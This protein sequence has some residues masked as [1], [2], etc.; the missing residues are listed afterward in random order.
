MGRT[1]TPAEIETMAEG[2]RRLARIL[3]ELRAAVRPGVRTIELDR[4]AH[5]LIAKG[6]DTP[7]FLGYKPGG[8]G[9]PYPASLCASVNDGV[10]HGV[11]SN[12][13]L[14]EGDVLKLDLGLVHKELY[15]DAA[16][17]V[18][19]G[20]ISEEAKKLISATKKALALGVA[21]AKAGNTLGDI[22]HAVQNYVEQLGF[23]VVRAL[24]GHGVGQSL[25]EDPYV[26]NFGKPG[27]GEKLVPGMVLALEPMVT[28]GRCHVKQLS[29]DSFV[30]K[31]GSLAAHFEHTVAI[32]KHGSRILTRI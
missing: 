25:H 14:R 15:V 4:L 2:G 8:A 27:E 19:V 6:G 17:T 13:A 32:T 31:D 30:T 12:Y 11:P 10:V 24:T 3:A 23:S 21:A 29:D 18:G 9:K 16:V 22:G 26:Y 1:K 28:A 7:A 20:K 5:D